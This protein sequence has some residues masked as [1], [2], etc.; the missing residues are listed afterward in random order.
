MKTAIVTIQG[1][2]PYSPSKHYS[3]DEFPKLEEGKEANSDYE[4]RTWRERAHYNESGEC[5]MPPMGFKKSVEMAA[6]F[7]SIGI[8]GRGKATYT[9]HFK[10]GVLVTEPLMLGVQ[11][12]AV[13]GN[14]LFI[15]SDGRS[16]GG[17]RVNKCFPIF[18]EWGGDVTFYILDDTITRD[19]FE[20]CIKEAGNFIGLGSFRPANGGYFGRFVVKGVKWVNGK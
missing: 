20:R 14:W 13:E 12:D 18:N 1:I 2:S 4:K 17:S 10:A 15:P 6:K 11:K 7:L 3:Q 19:V 9:K 8:P 16:G 5:F